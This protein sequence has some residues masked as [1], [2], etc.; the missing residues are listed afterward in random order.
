MEAHEFEHLRI[1]Q[2]RFEPALLEELLGAAPSI[3]RREGGD[4][5]IG[6]A[7]VERR[8]RPLNLFLRA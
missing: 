8:I 3:V 2:D 1:A 4:V 6:H 5:V 7:Y